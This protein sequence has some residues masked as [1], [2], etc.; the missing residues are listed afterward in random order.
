MSLPPLTVGRKLTLSFAVLGVFLVGV[1]VAGFSGMGK[2]ATAHHAVVNRAVP[3]Q[4]AADAARAA[5]SDMHFS[6]TAYGLAGA[7]A[8]G[9]F[10]GDRATFRAALA[11]LGKLSNTPADRRAF[12][13]IQA[14]ATAFDRGDA[15]LFAAVRA[16]D[17]ARVRAI[18]TGPQN[19]ASDALVAALTRFQHQ[20]LRDEQAQTR[21]FA[22]VQS[23]S[24]LMMVLVALL[25]GLI[26]SAL[27]WLLVRSITRAVRQVLSAAE[28]IAVGELDHHVDIRSRD[29]LG[30]MA[31]AFESMVDYLR[32][33]A[34][35]AT[36]I[37]AG[38]LTVDVV[39]KGDGDVLG[40]AFA[41]MV[42][43]LRELVGSVA[44]SAETLSSA[45]HQM[46]GTSDE[47]GRAVGEIAAAV[48]DVAHGA[49][50]QVRLVESTRGAVQGA[51][52]A[53]S[54]SS[55]TASTTVRAA[56]QAR[57]VARDGVETADHASAAIELVATA[58]A[59]VGEAIGD[60]AERSQRIGGIVETI[61]GIAEQTNLLALNAAIEAARAGDHGR[62]FAVVAEEVRKL[63]EESQ[64]SAAQIAGLVS[65]IQT[66]T[67]RVVD[68]VADS[69][70]RT[71]DGVASVR[72]TRDAFEQIGRAVD[73]VT[74]QVQEIAAGIQ[75]IAAEAE[76]AES[77]V[78]EV[79][80]VAEESSAS[81]EQVSAST[82]QTSASTQQIAASAQNL[83]GTAE[84]LAQLVG[85]FTLTT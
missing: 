77:D 74:A 23:S 19:D 60:L 28:G 30:A 16:N 38:D 56:Q 50:R 51:A 8:R 61:T 64:T 44:L 36:H 29:E 66:E 57:G 1:I 15:K 11:H 67:A 81:A 26:G 59:Q 42:A 9:D 84:Q 13:R 69:A 6:Q 46:A 82:Q 47:T 37:A 32:A 43:N 35:A 12:A 7:S 55:E 24:R 21:Q 14:A 33:S 80:G 76:R 41:T 39:A 52:R 31:A 25:A 62:G 18:V 54:A 48:T 49:E 45:S 20:V 65:E 85:R 58:S 68:V 4:L 83:A 22:S 40:H 71:D 73:D 10:T 2:M 17:A 79:A 63:A 27:A 34:D 3:K 78:T 5:A 75:E 53:A 72:R 70:R